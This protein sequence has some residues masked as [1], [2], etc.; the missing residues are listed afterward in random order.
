METGK[1]SPQTIDAYIAKYPAEVQAILQHLRAVIR[2]A[3]PEAKE[4]ISYGIP[5]FYAE[6]NLVHFA[7]YQHHIG[8]YPTSSGIEHFHDELSGYELSKGTVRFPLDKPV[9]YDLVRRITEFRVAASRV[10]AQDKRTR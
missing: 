7:A 2:E 5:T 9:P 3:A 8:F 6:E 10:K 4:K 1:T